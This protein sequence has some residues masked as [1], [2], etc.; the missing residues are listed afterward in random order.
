[1]T[2]VENLAFEHVILFIARSLVD[3]DFGALFDDVYPVEF[4][5]GT[6]GKVKEMGVGWEKAMGEA[7]CG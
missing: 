1:M 6:N 2:W 7:S 5:I 3:G 4:R